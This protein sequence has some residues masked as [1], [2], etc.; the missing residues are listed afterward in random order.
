MEADD[1][2]VVEDLTKSN[3]EKF[4]KFDPIYCSKCNHVNNG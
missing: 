3:E 1:I 4:I 2:E